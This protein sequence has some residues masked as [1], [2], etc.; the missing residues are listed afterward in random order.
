MTKL[1][2]QTIG[3][4]LREK[5][6]TLQ[7]HEAVVYQDQGIRYTYKEFYELSGQVAKGLIGLGVEK[8]EHIAAWA[9]NVPEW[10]L[11]QFG[12]ARAGAVLVTVNTS[13][14]ESELEYLLQQSDSTALFLIE[15]FKGN[16]YVNIAQNIVNDRKEKVPFLKNLVYLGE[17]GH[18]PE[19]MKNWSYLLD[20][21]KNVT[22][23]ELNKREAS[24]HYNDVINMQ[25]TSGTTGF[26]KGVM[27]THYNIV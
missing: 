27:L 20:L 16:S 5:A 11:L 23:E 19:G 17:Q 18:T 6:E 3:D 2:E 1:L 15:G 22:D 24:L 8:G 25:Y 10:L 14:Q 26:P 4:L 12:S 7:D 9:T 13:Y 21:A